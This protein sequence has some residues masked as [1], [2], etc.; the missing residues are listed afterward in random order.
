M[1]RVRTPIDMGF[2]YWTPRGTGLPGCSGTRKATALKNE[3]RLWLLAVDP[4]RRFR[5]TACAL[6]SS[7]W[8]TWKRLRH[9]T[10]S[11]DSA[12]LAR[13]PNE[14]AWQV[15]WARTRRVELARWRLLL[16]A[17]WT[18][19]IAGAGC[20]RSKIP[21]TSAHGT[22]LLPTSF[23]RS[24][25]YRFHVQYATGSGGLSCHG[26]D[27]RCQLVAHHPSCQGR[28]YMEG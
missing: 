23:P 8:G 13:A 3:M 16:R 20:Y 10:A 7:E 15:R 27:Q 22:T 4:S 18:F 12:S 24:R 2:Q 14:H 21:L 19:I 26:S 9:E 5:E 25:A 11:Q 6:E 1:R 17:E 28:D